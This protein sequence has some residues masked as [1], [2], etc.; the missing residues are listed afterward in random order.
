MV[1]GKVLLV[2]CL[3]AFSHCYTAGIGVFYN[4]TCRCL[5]LLNAFQCSV[6]ISD[7]VVRKR[8]TLQLCG[9]SDRGLLGIGLTIKRRGLVWVFAVAQFLHFFKMKIKSTWEIRT[10]VAH[11]LAKIVGNSCIVRSGMFKGFHR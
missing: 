3:N 8:F 4:H 10:T 6:G 11:L 1:S 9:S 2:G 7:I 5:E